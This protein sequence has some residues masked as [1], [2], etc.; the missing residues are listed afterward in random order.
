MIIEFKRHFPFGIYYKFKDKKLIIS[1]T[2]KIP[3]NADYY[4]ILVQSVKNF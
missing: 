2:E 4:R 3:E 1:D